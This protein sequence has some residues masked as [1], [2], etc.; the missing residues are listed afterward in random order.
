MGGGDAAGNLDNQGEAKH[1][2]TYSIVLSSEENV[3]RGSQNKVIDGIHEDSA[4][5]CTAADCLAS[6][7]L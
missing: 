3:G 2:F 4:K 1:G 5:I 7:K 6:A